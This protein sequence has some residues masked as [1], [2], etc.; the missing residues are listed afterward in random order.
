LLDALGYGLPKGQ[1]LRATSFTRILERAAGRPESELLSQLILRSQAQ[2]VYASENIGHF[3]LALRRYAHFTSPIRRYADLIV[4][5]ALIRAHGLGPGGL[6]DAALARLEAI[7]EQVS[8]TERRAAAA[9]RDALDRYTAAFLADRVGALFSG[10]ISGVTRFGLFVTLDETGAEGLVP[11]ATL[12]QDYYIHDEAQHRLVGE[13]WG[14]S[15]RLAAPVKVRL[16]E[17]DPLLGST[18]FA[19]A[20]PDGG[21]GGGDSD[22]EGADPLSDH[23][24]RA[25]ADVKKFRPGGAARR[26]SRSRSNS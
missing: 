20:G 6:D 5:R 1:V 14:R 7:G 9:E 13:R 8:A 21:P 25:T 10:R 15:Y 24:L 2:A 4:H 3:G 18:L 23:G 17:A 22:T 11:I 12:P 19:L 16:V 26:S